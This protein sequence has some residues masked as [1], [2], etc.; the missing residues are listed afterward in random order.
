MDKSLLHLS[1]QIFSSILLANVILSAKLAAAQIQNT[2]PQQVTSTSNAPA[3]SPT[4]TNNIIK[5]QSAPTISPP[6]NS[7]PQNSPPQNNPPVVNGGSFI[8]IPPTS[9][10]IPQPQQTIVNAP[11]SPNLQNGKI[12]VGNYLFDPTRSQSLAPEERDSI[13][14]TATASTSSRNRHSGKTN[15]AN[16]AAKTTASTEL[17]MQ[18]RLNLAQI[19]YDLAA[20]KLAELQATTPLAHPTP[21][22]IAAQSAE[23]VAAAE[24]SKVQAQVRQSMETLKSQ[25]F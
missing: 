24:L 15:P 10:T 3:K 20:V 2:S 16:E 9:P 13:E 23:R 14:I 25:Q 7:P 22:I 17:Q 12:N 6:Q 19:A 21:A 8:S 18:E 5:T 4:P 1:T 11:I